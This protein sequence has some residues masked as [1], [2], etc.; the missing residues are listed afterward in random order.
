MASLRRGPGTWTATLLL[1]LVF[2]LAGCGGGEDNSLDT[3][4]DGGSQM[5]PPR[6]HDGQGM[7]IRILPYF[8][9]NLYCI[10]VGTAAADN[11]ALTCD[12]V[13]WHQEN[14][15]PSS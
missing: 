9:H 4:Y 1:S 12:F 6:Y 5:G 15:G 10:E 13:R 8:G 11:G 3:R 14:D 7:E 2:A